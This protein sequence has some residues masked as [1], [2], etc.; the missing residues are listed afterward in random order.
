MKMGKLAFVVLSMLLVLATGVNAQSLEKRHQIGL[1]FG[2]W[3]QVADTRTVVSTDGV[4]TSV[5]S[6][7][8]VGMVA[9]NYWLKENVA[10]DI[11]VGGMGVDIESEVGILGVTSKFSTIGH[12]LMGAKYYFPS[13]TYGSSV[14]PF[15]M[16]SV[17]PF[18][19]DQAET[20][21]GLVVATEERTEVAFGGKLAMGVDF[22]V[23]RHFMAGLTVGYN[24][25]SDFDEPIGGSDNYSGPEFLIGVGYLF[26]SGVN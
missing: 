7:G 17:G 13:S 21:V 25:M 1:R 3:S 10:L 2:M 19:G 8:A 4:T 23:S 9:Y 11:S 18:I 14:R 15:A 20:R 22:P 24:F 5:G 12:I 26:G 6:S 16:A